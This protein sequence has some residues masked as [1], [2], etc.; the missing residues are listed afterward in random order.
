[1]LQRIEELKAPISVNRLLNSNNVLY[2]PNNSNH[3]RCCYNPS[4]R[5][6]WN[7]P[8]MEINERKLAK[9]TWKSTALGRQKPIALLEWAIRIQAN[10]EYE[11]IERR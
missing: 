4:N 5:L 7:K 9:P 2:N 3:S 1:M 10:R 11:R 8:T 6:P